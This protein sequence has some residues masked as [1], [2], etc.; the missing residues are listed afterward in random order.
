MNSNLLTRARQVNDQQWA[1][2]RENISKISKEHQLKMLEFL[3]AP[4]VEF[5]EHMTWVPDHFI[6]IIKSFAM[7]AFCHALDLVHG[8]NTE[9]AL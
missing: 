2:M 7:M 1:A 9:A 3:N 6:D 5:R 4:A 8:D